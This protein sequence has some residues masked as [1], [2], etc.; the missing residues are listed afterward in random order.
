MNYVERCENM[1]KKIAIGCGTI[2]LILIIAFISFIIWFDSMISDNLSKKEIFELV[3]ENY[4]I[5]LND[6]I[7]NDFTDTEKLK[8]IKEVYSD[9]E[10]IDVYCGGTGIGSATSY[11]GFYYSPDG[12][13][14]DAWCGSNFGRTADELT[15][16]GKGFAIKNSNDDNY[17]YTEKI[18]D[19][20]YYYEAH[21]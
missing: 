4:D 9:T 18:R 15:P 6:I 1:K 20:F 12:L 21:F 14:K 5:I 10:V 11:Y 7:E 19:N 13:P 8:G 17:Y 2:V 3:N 16:E